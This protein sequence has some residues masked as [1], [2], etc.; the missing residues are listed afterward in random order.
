ML[1]AAARAAVERTG[2]SDARKYLEV[3]ARLREI[4]L[5][6]DHALLAETT[7]LFLHDAA[8]MVVV[9]K[10]GFAKGDTDALHRA[11][12]RLKGAALNLG[13]AGVAANARTIEEGARRGEL[14]DVAASIAAIESELKCVTDF[15]IGLAKDGAPL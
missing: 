1:T 15:L 7:H 5:L 13:V 9:M 4:G 8:D 12:H 2:M 10:E 14:V 3:V 11:S 6:D